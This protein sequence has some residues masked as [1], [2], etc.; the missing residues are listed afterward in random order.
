MIVKYAF[1]FNLQV[2]FPM[3]TQKHKRQLLT[4]GNIIQKLHYGPFAVNWWFFTGIKTK[5]SHIPIHVNM[6]IKVE[7]NQTEFII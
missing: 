5:I 6:R 1:Q 3:S 7:L 2:Q 4:S